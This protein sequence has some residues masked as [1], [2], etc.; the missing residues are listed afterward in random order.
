MNERILVIEDEPD[1]RD[2]IAYNLS[3]EGFRVTALASGEEGLKSA[4]NQAP[5]LVVLDLML[6]GVYGL[7]VCKLLKSDNRTA[8]VPII[9]LTARTE[10]SDVI[11]GLEVGADDYVIK[12]FSPRLLVA[13]IRARLRER[14]DEPEKIQKK[15]NLKRISMDRSRH[16]VEVDGKPITL[17]PTEFKLLWMLAKNPGLVFSRYE[18]VNSVKGEDAIVTDRSVDVQI[19]GLRKKLCSC[20]DYIET[21]RGVGYRLRQ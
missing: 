1:I 6:P 16:S 2:M 19:V 15:I 9:M 5:D 4:Q 18:I 8:G 20:A 10:E 11:S 13:R 21:V 14:T 7:D 12:P 17:T 3:K